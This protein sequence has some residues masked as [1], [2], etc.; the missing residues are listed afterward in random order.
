MYE[1]SD[2]LSLRHAIKDYIRFYCVERHQS[3]YHCKTLA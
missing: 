2:E 1:I 3:R